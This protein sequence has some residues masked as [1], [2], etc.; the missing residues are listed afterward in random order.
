M[1]RK[2]S[3]SIGKVLK[4][5][6]KLVKRCSKVLRRCERC[7][8]KLCNTCPESVDKLERKRCVRIELEGRGGRF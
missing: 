6:D 8:E 5:I 2:R 4:T 7:V 1:L 3:K